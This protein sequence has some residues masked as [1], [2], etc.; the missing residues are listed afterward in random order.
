VL[1]NQLVSSSLLEFNMAR[2]QSKSSLQNGGNKSLLASLR[3]TTLSTAPTP[4]KAALPSEIL[5]LILD[6]LSVPDLMRFARADHRCRDMVYE[7]A[8]WVRK[9][10]LMGV[11]DEATARRAADDALR[12]KKSEG[13]T[14][15]GAGTLFDAAEEQLSASGRGPDSGFAAPPLLTAAA[16]MPQPRVSAP[17][18]R[19]ALT[20]LARARSVRGIARHEYA[21]VHAALAPLYADLQRAR[22]RHGADSALF[23]VYRDPEDQARMLAQLRAFARADCAAGFRAREMQVVTVMGVFEAAALREFEA[24]MA[25]GDVA[26]R[27]KRY[28]H[29]LAYL[30]G[31]AAAIEAFVQGNAVM[32]ARDEFGSSLDCIRTAFSGHINLAPSEEYFRKMALAVN[33]QVDVID[34][35]FPPS[36]DALTSFVERL[37][38]DVISEYITQLF[39]EAHEQNLES[40]VKAVSGIFEQALRFSISVKPAK[41]SPTTFQAQTR[42]A[43]VKY[44]EQHIDLYL[45]E[46]VDFFKKKAEGEVENWEKLRLEQEASDESFLMS[47][48]NRK[49]AKQDF[50]SS[51]RNMLMVPVTAVSSLATPSKKPTESDA[52]K[53]AKRAS[54]SERP[55]TPG[56][57]D[58]P[59]SELAAKAAVMNS[60]MQ[61]IKGLLSIE[62]ALNVIHHAKG[63][64]ERIAK[65]V[66]LEGQ[67]GEEAREQCEVIFI[68]L[69]QIV[70]SKHVKGGF[71]KAVAHLGEY[72]PREITEHST[73]GVKPLVTFLELVNVG[74]LI[75][76]MVDVFYMQELVA[77][78]LSDPDDFVNPAVK[79]K[80]RFEQMLDERVAAG[81]NKGIDVL[82]EEIEY[83]CATT[84]LPS[85]FNPEME[86]D[87]RP[88]DIG[89]SET[90]KQVV[91]VVSSHVS[92]LVGSTDKN[93]LDVFNQEVGVRLFT[94]LC[95]HI[96]R[97]RISVEGAIKLIRY[98]F[99]R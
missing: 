19:D 12:T 98:D 79:E 43:I 68:T 22:S 37:V 29:V 99:Q 86:A 36:I 10:K 85:D 3:A 59:T 91:T 75:Q 41:S 30:N 63:S 26:G 2:P 84:Q 87:G 83:V 16:G 42:K 9:L 48:V 8:R 88:V 20:A 94:V 65:F 60:R 82:M 90:A 1:F 11:W 28:A 76:Q 35:A 40:Y 13:H 4:R 56:Q 38:E 55:S 70:G 14:G 57:G 52:T 96:K 54:T 17:T 23:R 27:M 61:G 34:Q 89:P 67:A 5:D 33:D 50:M 7:D 93:V 25:A 92:M 44:F 21:R 32:L 24:G 80:K 53:A 45:Q 74:D 58:A 31:G 78:K 81:L 49:A 73:K 47:N 66:K 97:Q 62:V 18:P 39:D 64:L 71:D 46:E 15:A 69:V 95:K 6:Y 72:K 51:F 77:P